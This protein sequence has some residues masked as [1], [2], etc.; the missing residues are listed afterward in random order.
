MG[1]QEQQLA[2]AREASTTAVSIYSPSAAIAAVKTL[3]VCNTTGGAVKFRIFH[4]DDGTTY[5]E[6]TALY[7]DVPLAANQTVQID[8]FIAM[9]N[10]NGNLAY[11]SSVASAITITVYGSEITT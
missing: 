2:Q 10:V 3:I 6:S 1:F 5:D 7:W 9:D 4:D 8:T 11:R